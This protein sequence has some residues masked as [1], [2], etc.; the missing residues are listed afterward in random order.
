MA[1]AQTSAIELHDGLIQRIPQRQFT[2][3]RSMYIA[4]SLFMQENNV[5]VC[6]YMRRKCPLKYISSPWDLPFLFAQYCIFHNVFL[7]K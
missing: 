1:R 3:M 5:C 6:V 7:N 2:Y 4:R